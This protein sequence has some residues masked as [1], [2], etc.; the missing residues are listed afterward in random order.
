[1]RES[2]RGTEKAQR[3]SHPWPLTRGI[4]LKNHIRVCAGKLQLRSFGM[5]LLCEPGSLDFACH[6]KGNAEDL[7]GS[8]KNC[9]A[10]S[11]APFHSASTGGSPTA[12]AASVITVTSSSTVSSSPS[13]L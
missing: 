12:A 10:S 11:P 3:S 1:M 9:S 2:N 4:L 8:A 13:L 6:G 5:I 7:Q